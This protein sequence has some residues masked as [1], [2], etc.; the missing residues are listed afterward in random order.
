MRWAPPE[1]PLLLYRTKS[2][3]QKPSHTPWFIGGLWRKKSCVILGESDVMPFYPEKVKRWYSHFFSIFLADVEFEIEFLGLAAYE[4]VSSTTFV[5]IDYG[6][7][8]TSGPV[9]LVLDPVT[10]KM[11]LTYDY[12]RPV[13]S[14]DVKVTVRNNADSLRDSLTVRFA[15]SQYFV[16]TDLIE[17]PE[18]KVRKQL[19]I[20]A[21]RIFKASGGLGTSDTQLFSVFDF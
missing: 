5:E 7:G 6:N 11:S 9:Q 17:F 14:A 12:P 20:S 16:S 10:K 18:G 15:S 3:S 21:D 19:K 1:F 4:P 8:Q 13:S 2:C